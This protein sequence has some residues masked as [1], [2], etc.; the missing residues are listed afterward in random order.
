MEIISDKNLLSYVIVEERKGCD[1]EQ[2]GER[3]A[4][5]H[6]NEDCS[7]NCAVLRMH[8][9][10]WATVKIDVL[11]L[12][13][14][15]GGLL[16]RAAAVVFAA[17]VETSEQAFHYNVNAYLAVRVDSVDEHGQDEGWT[18]DEVPVL[19]QIGVLASDRDPIE[20]GALR[21]CVHNK[22][23]D[24]GVEESGDEDAGHDGGD[25]LGLSVVSDQLDEVHAHH[26][27]DR[28]YYSDHH[29]HSFG[30]GVTSIKVFHVGV[31]QVTFGNL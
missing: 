30:K 22:E 29:S 3:E 5:E 26:A 4:I 28:V 9:V 12:G 19:C 8:L 16:F 20:D 24:G 1:W 14:A 10:N 25:L 15:F 7:Q 13:L 17:L 11:L 31:A 23:Q 6:C 27:D 18:Q 2:Q 21:V